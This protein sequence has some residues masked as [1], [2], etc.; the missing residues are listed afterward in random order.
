MDKNCKFHVSVKIANM[1]G[2]IPLKYTFILELSTSNRLDFLKFLSNYLPGEVFKT[3]R[4]NILEMNKD[5]LQFGIIIGR[6]NMKIKMALQAKQF[7]SVSS[8]YS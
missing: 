2:F 3:L 5:C 6:Y 7:C 1:V 8:N 4:S